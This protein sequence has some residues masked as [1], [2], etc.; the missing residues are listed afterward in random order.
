MRLQAAVSLLQLSTVETYAAAM[1]PKFV[2]LALMVQVRVTSQSSIMFADLAGQLQDS[3]FNV[4]Y[5]F[6][7][8]LVALL[9]VRKLPER[10]NVIPFLTVL[11]PESEV[12][13]L[14][15]KM[16]NLPGRR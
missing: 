1:T 4:R 2:R 14:V 3:C 10:Y 13:G 11:D 16:H 9:H 5:I 8:K 15:R 6:L 12:K 7:T